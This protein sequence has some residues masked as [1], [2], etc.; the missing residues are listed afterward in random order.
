[1]AFVDAPIHKRSDPVVLPPGL[2]AGDTIGIAAPAGPFQSDLFD[3]GVAVLRG[4]GFEVHIPEAIFQRDGFLAGPDKARAEVLNTLFRDPE[5]D[6]ILCARGGYGSTR[7]LPYLDWEAIGR[8]PKAFVGFSDITVLHWVLHQ[9][10]GLVSFHG[11]MATTLASAGE[12]SL[13]HLKRVLTTNA[14]LDLAPSGTR[15]LQ[16]GDAVGKVV[17]G[18]LTLLCHLVGTPYAPHFDGCIL[19]VEDVAEAPYRID[20]MLMQMS[21]AGCLQGISGLVLGQFEDCGALEDIYAVFLRTFGPLGIPIVAGFPIGHG[22]ENTTL[23][24]GIEARLTTRPPGLTYARAG[25]F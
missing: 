24:L 10:T 16:K 7:V 1:M 17:G 21:L 20:R 9:R 23:P 13:E 8:H 3:R 22:R 19:F 11:P 14:P 15:V 2:H 25:T 6:A 4:M 12:Q 5:V 18:N